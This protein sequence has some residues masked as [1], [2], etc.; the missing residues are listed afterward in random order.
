MTNGGGKFETER[1]A[2][3][4]RQL[5]WPVD[6]AQFICG[7]TPMRNLSTKYRSVL[8]VGGEGEKCRQV[9]ESYGFQ[10]V[11]TPGDIIKDN[12]HTTPFRK[13]TAEEMSNSRARN[14]GEHEIEAILVF[15]DSR[16]WAGDQQIILD[17]LL[18]ENG[19]L[20][21]RCETFDQGPP[22]FFAHN[23]FV[24]STS[25]SHTRLGMGALRSSLAAMYRALTQGKELEST[26]FGKPELG[27]FQYATELLEYWCCDRYNLPPSPSSPSSSSSSSSPSSEE[28]PAALK[29]V[30]FV[31]DTPTS[32]I[33]GTNSYNAS[34]LSG[35]QEWYSVL[36]R[37]GVW[38]EGGGEE[39]VCEKHT[40]QGNLRPRTTVDDVLAAVR[41]GIRREGERKMRKEKE[42]MEE[43][44]VGVGVEGGV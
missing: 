42:E 29:T 43:M 6:P 3:L 41:F 10:D 14:F 16:D 30:Y 9:A 18:S 44:E 17:V 36:V 12:M 32:D 19:R 15:A 2:D 38:Q 4:S 25:H 20:G 33:Q 31:G 26:V 40:L 1:C 37:T 11:I 24:W 22:L 35:T 39:G 34:R 23:D 21:T 5:Q 28:G 13:L 27:T 7:H 8:V